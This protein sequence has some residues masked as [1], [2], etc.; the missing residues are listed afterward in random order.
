MYKIAIITDSN[1]GISPKEAEKIG[2]YVLPMPFFVND[3]MHYEGID[4]TQE[5]FY[6]NL[7]EDADV[8]TSMPSPGDVMELWNEALVENDFVIHIPMSSSL[9]GSCEAAI[10]FAKSDYE[11]KV[12]VVDNKRISMTLKES[13]Y[14]A[15]ALKEAGKT[16]SEIKEILEKSGPDSFIYLSV[17]TLK[18]LKKGG[19]IS[20]AAA[21]IGTVLN[22]K[23]VLLFRGGKIE[24][25]EKTR[26]NKAS[27]KAIL[28][29]IEAEMKE[30]FGDEV[31][32][33]TLKIPYSCTDED[34]LKWLDE[35]VDHFPKFKKE[36]IELSKLSL[37]IAC[38]TGPGVVAL[39][40]TK[41]L[42]I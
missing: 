21:A 27:R 1:S 22:L 36:D 40:C 29:G 33:L 17:D 2:V 25:Y 37:S 30:R 18:Y 16:P 31:H 26:G 4:F 34:A 41:K 5:D 42:D 13:V 6:R 11:G 7:E 39:T 28:K 15:V 12:F 8:S 23:P 9:S 10:G 20:P 19:R 32:K 24:P 14:D 3:K 35:V 38:H